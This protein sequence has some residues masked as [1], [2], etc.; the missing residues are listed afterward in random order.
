MTHNNM[1]SSIEILGTTKYWLEKASKQS[2]IIFNPIY[3]HFIFLFD[4][5]L[6]IEFLTYHNWYLEHTAS[7]DSSG[8]QWISGLQFKKLI[9]IIRVYVTKKKEEKKSYITTEVTPW[10]WQPTPQKRRRL[11]PAACMIFKIFKLD[12]IPSKSIKCSKHRIC[13]G[14]AIAKLLSTGNTSS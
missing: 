2:Y 11:T 14:T 9:C 1:L 3:I 12:D 4:I 8:A 10:T 13:H 7:P 5:Y 6:E